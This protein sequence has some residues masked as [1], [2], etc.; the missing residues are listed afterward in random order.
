MKFPFDYKTMFAVFSLD[1]TWQALNYVSINIQN[2]TLYIISHSVLKI[3][4]LKNGK[5][6]FKKHRG[7]EKKQIRI[8]MSLK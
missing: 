5:K 4:L 3:K 7:E 1:Y 8:K 2:K 6:T